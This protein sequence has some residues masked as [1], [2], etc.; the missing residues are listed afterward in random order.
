MKW[1]LIILIFVLLLLLSPMSGQETTLTIQH[2]GSDKVQQVENWSAI[3]CTN[4]GHLHLEGEVRIAIAAPT[5]T[6]PSCKE[7]SPD[8][9]AT[10]AHVPPGRALIV[11]CTTKAEDEQTDRDLAFCKNNVSNPRPESEAER[12]KY[13][14]EIS[15]CLQDRS[16]FRRQKTH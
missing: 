16:E 1:T 3:G 9:L 12:N 14:A 15:Q 4:G 5:C 11:Y 8:K 6:D 2:Q 7:I 13:T 10:G